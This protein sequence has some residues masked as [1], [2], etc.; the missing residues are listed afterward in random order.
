VSDLRYTLVSD[1][2]SDQILKHPINWLLQQLTDRIP[3]ARWADPTISN[4]GSFIL[5]ERIINAIE[6]YPCELLF[7]HRDAEKQPREKRISEIQK[8]MKDLPAPPQVCI[9]PVRMTEAW[10]LING[11]L[12]QR[13]ANN[14][15]GTTAINLPALNRI[16][17]IPDPKSTLYQLLR[18]AN[19]KSG[20]SAKKFKP[21]IATYR[22]A[23]LIEDY[24]PLRQFAAFRAFERDL[25][26][27]LSGIHSL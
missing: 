2:S 17:S 19:N 26:E 8:A 18:Q 6:C 27:V 5:R 4:C 1:G 24:S 21:A 13:A 16:E 15:A 14:P 12:L 22:L 9:I 7:I 20:R 23:E 11:S 10:F 3:I 25:R